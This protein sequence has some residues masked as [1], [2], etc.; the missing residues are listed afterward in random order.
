[1]RASKRFYAERGF[2]VAKS[3]G[4]KYVEF[5]AAPDGVKL[6]LYKRGALAKDA[7]VPAEGGGSHRIV[8]RGDAGSFVDPDGFRWEPAQA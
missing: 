3:Y 5:R 7:N 2:A 1:V 4:S 8:I 6:G